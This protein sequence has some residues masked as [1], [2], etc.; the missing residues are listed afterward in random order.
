[1]KKYKGLRVLYVGSHPLFTEGASAVHM[2]K[3]C[4]AMA[5]LGIEVEC[6]LPGRVNRER[7]FSY[8]SIKTPFRATSIALSGWMA[9][10]PL[11][12]FLSAFYAR[13]KRNDLDF[14]LTRDLIF[15]W[16]ATRVFG[17]PTVYDAHHPPVNWAAERIIGSFSRSKNLLGMSFNSQGLRET[18]S[19]LGIAGRNSVV[20]ANGFER[21]A[22]EGEHDVSSL[23]A[24]LGLPLDRKIVCYCGNT[25]RGRG[26]EILVRAAVQMPEIEFLIV[27]GREQDNALWREMARQEG[28][29]NFRMEGFVAQREVSSYLLA[30]DILV[31]PYS[32]GVT[33][34]DGTE[35]GEFT[36]PLK[37]FEYMAAGKP[38]V[39][40]GVQSVLEVLRQGENSVVT[41]PDDAEE[42]IRALGLVLKDS[43]LCL[44]ISEGARSDAVKYTW[45]KRIEKIINGVV[46]SSR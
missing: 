37:L 24:R 11:H 35:A 2:L 22:F 41:P 17:I 19:R 46:I 6:V 23:R 28:V 9:R 14:V 27:G 3:M 25:Y 36:S 31:M 15:A 4:Q 26:L 7:L 8:Y 5:N 21:E 38:I 16:F 42:F 13:G 20:A 44:R 12:G 29:T 39:A 33:I 30:S 45:E 10:R 18:Y 1:M 43:D 32:S 40:T 34:R